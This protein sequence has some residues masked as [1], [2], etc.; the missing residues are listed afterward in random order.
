MKF[1]AGTNER[2]GPERINGRAHLRLARKPD[3]PKKAYKIGV[4][5]NVFSPREEMKKTAQA[6]KPKLDIPHARGDGQE[7]FISNQ[8]ETLIVCAVSGLA[9]GYLVGKLSR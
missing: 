4:C 8:T 5:E 2:N 3:L 1:A 7:R 6:A 9:L